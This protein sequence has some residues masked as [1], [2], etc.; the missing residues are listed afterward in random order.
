MV[1]DGSYGVPAGLIYS[2]PLVSKGNA[3]WSIVPGV[4]ID[5]EARVRL[6][7]SAA[8]LVSERDAVKELLGACGVK[9]IR[10]ELALRQSQLSARA[11]R[12]VRCR[13][14]RWSPIQ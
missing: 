12:S 9:E 14:G 8:E 2:F 1:S 5:V 13:P 6:E 7:V 10:S 11:V 4:P 3:D